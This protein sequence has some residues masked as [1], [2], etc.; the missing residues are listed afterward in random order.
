MFRLAKLKPREGWNTVC[1][2]LVIVTLGVLLALAVQQWAENRTIRGKLA[3]TQKA[4]RVELAE[5]YTYAVEFRTV[6]PCVQAQLRQLL[7]H[8]VSIEA[9]NDPVPTY[10][11]STGSFVLR[12]PSKVHPTFVWEAAVN[13]GLIQR[14]Q[15][16][17]RDQLAGHYAQIADMQRLISAN[18]Q[19]AAGMAALAQRLPIDPAIRYEIVKDIAQFSGRLDTLDLNYGQEIE[20]VQ[21]VEMVPPARDAQA[22]TTRYGTYQFCKDH[23]LPMRSFKDAMQAVPN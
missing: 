11:D 8:V 2:E 20:N 5:H 21:K 16:S 4:L 1:W 6:Y 17:F 12:L 23:G 13:D 15:P 22:M 9:V 18:D 19:T 10:K 3:A 7:D 14:F